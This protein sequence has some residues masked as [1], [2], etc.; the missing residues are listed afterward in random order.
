MQSSETNQKLKQKNMKTTEALTDKQQQVLDYIVAH[1]DST[2]DAIIEGTGTNKLPAYNIFKQLV[3]KDK[4]VINHQNTPATFSSIKQEAKIVKSA[5]KKLVKEE[6]SK[7][8][9]DEAALPTGRNTGKL[10]FNGEFYGK[11]RLVLAVVNKYVQDNPKVT[12]AKL[13]EVFPDELQPRYGIVQ[14]VTKAKK[15]SEDGRDRFFLK[16]EELIKVGEKKVAVCNQFGAH[17]LPLKHFKALGFV[18][19]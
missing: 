9:D 2:A 10:K 13:K 11:G 15:M 19:K 7:P 4:I 18:I 6:K 17:N 12:L 8:E 14:E 1:P 5:D 3:A 16:P